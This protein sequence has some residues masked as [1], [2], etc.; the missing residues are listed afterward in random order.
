[1]WRDRDLYRIHNGGG[2]EEYDPCKKQ[3]FGMEYLLDLMKA[4]GLDLGRERILLDIV[5]WPLIS[6]M[7]TN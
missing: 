3:R 6:G 4:Y 5:T 7:T 2:Q 1:M